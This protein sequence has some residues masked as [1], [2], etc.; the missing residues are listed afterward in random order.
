[1]ILK[2]DNL[3]NTVYF[4]LVPNSQFLSPDCSLVT[5]HSPCS[6]LKGNV[7]E[8]GHRL[9]SPSILMAH[10]FSLFSLQP[11]DWKSLL[12][13]LDS[14]LNDFFLYLPDPP[15]LPSSLTNQTSNQQ[16]AIFIVV[17][18]LF[19]KLSPYSLSLSQNCKLYKHQHC[20]HTVGCL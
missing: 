15:N 20:V 6:C 16:P 10:H 1:M 8:L 19:V 3:M 13:L 18:L 4:P 11:F 14:C 9:I 12:L 2:K 17:F 5:S 7:H